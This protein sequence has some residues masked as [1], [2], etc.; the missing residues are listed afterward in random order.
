MEH[1]ITR[2]HWKFSL[3]SKAG[4]WQMFHPNTEVVPKTLSWPPLIY[5]SCVFNICE[6]VVRVLVKNEGHF[7][8]IKWAVGWRNGWVQGSSWRL[9]ENQA[10]WLCHQAALP[11]SLCC[12]LKQKNMLVQI[13]QISPLLRLAGMK[14]GSSEKQRS[15][16]W[17]LRSW[18]LF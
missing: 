5:S 9:G 6:F 15:T 11:G 18:H 16:G 1:R 2:S 10:A 8:N 17:A 14:Q 12:W 3:D 13:L 7:T 4:S